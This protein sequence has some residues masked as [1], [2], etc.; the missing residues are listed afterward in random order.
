[1]KFWILSGLAC[2][3]VAMPA[4]A[5]EPSHDDEAERVE[6]YHVEAPATTQAAK[7]L[8]SDKIAAVSTILSQEKLDDAA[9]E[10]VHKESYSLEAAVDALRTDKAIEEAALDSVDEAVQALHY[11]SENHEEAKVRTWFSTLQDAAGKI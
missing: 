5:T 10:T 2:L 8:L 7:K 1:M 3:A 11:A 6:H 9:L 4:L